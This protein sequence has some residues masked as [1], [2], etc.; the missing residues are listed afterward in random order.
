MFGF[1]GKQNAVVERKILI[2]ALDREVDLQRASVEVRAAGLMT[3]AS[4][5]VAAAS[6]LTGV[7]SL[8]Q[9]SAWF[10]WSTIASAAA[11][12]LGVLVLLP[13]LGAEVDIDSAESDYWNELDTVALHGFMKDK[14][15]VLKEDE[16]ALIWRRWVLLVGFACL[17]IS[18][19]LAALHLLFL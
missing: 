7:Q 19:L 17:A 9:M 2:A 16:H 12:I 18:L 8:D 6:I 3:R 15:R 13:R 11:A 5:L 14:L 4:I 1:G 10:L